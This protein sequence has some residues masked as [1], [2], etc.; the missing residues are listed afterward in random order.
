M[1]AAVLTSPDCRIASVREWQAC[2][3]H[4]VELIGRHGLRR[5][6]RMIANITRDALWRRR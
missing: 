5:Y 6:D 1:S 4:V 3:R 2:G